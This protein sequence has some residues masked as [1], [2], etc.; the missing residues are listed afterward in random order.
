M[1]QSNGTFLFQVTMAGDF[2]LAVASVMIARLGNDDV[3][4][5]LSQVRRLSVEMARRRLFAELRKICQ[6]SNYIELR[7]Q[8]AGENEFVQMNN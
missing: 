3:T 8:S 4:L 2:I 5:C 1:R 6:F 7:E